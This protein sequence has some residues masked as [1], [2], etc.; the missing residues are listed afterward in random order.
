MEQTTAKG[1][2]FLKVT[3]VLMIIGG[4]IRI[5]AAAGALSSIAFLVVLYGGAVSAGLLYASGAFALVGGILQLIAGIT[6]VRNCNKP[7]K[8]PACIKWGVIV[9]ILCV[10]GT[11]LSMAGGTPFP[12][13]SF[14]VGLI[15]PILYILG[16][17]KNKQ[18]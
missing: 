5:I 13:A 3:G 16:A 4:I 17:Y 18:G 11:I 2:G 6:G 12:V 14:L 15:L 8:A 9:I 7:E 1:A 10:I